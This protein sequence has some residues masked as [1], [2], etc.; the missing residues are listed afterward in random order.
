MKIDPLIMAIQACKLL[1]REAITTRPKTFKAL[2]K[3]E[4][5]AGWELAELLTAKKKAKT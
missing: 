4:E 2:D 5:V 1:A 3:A